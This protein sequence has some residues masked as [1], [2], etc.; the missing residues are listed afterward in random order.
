MPSRATIDPIPR[1]YEQ[2]LWVVF[3]S[4]AA[5]TRVVP[6]GTYAY[7][8]ETNHDESAVYILDARR[9]EGAGDGGDTYQYSDTAS[10]GEW[11]YMCGACGQV[12]GEGVYTNG[13]KVEP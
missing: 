5:I 12:C 7:A 10:G 1:R 13:G 6:D 4:G 11:R 9:Q 8:Y 3:G 2:I